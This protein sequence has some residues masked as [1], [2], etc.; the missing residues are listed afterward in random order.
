[1]NTVKNPF[2]VIYGKGPDAEVAAIKS[3][4]VILL[5]DRLRRSGLTQKEWSSKLGCSE[6]EISRVKNGQISGVSIEKI[7]KHLFSLG[8]SLNAI[9]EVCDST[10]VSM[11]IN[12]K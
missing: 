3:K 10:P 8:F 6:S 4:L 12:I 1:M 9:L 2:E 11:R 5:T 7:L